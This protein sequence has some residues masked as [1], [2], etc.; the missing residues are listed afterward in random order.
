MCSHRQ[1]PQAPQHSLK[2]IRSEMRDM[3]GVLEASSGGGGARRCTRRWGWGLILSVRRGAHVEC[4]EEE[5]GVRSSWMRMGMC[6]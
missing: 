5:R 4:C 2:S 1:H 6:L 3:R